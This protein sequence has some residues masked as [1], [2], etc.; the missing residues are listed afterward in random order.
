M[1]IL[2]FG[3][4]NPN[5]DSRSLWKTKAHIEPRPFS[6]GFQRPFTQVTL[7]KVLPDSSE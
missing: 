6:A 1:V 5:P 3:N 2:D 4:A 7:K